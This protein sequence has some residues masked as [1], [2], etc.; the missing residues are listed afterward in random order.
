M[1]F[2]NIIERRSL[3][4]LRILII[5]KIRNKKYKTNSNWSKNSKVDFHYKLFKQR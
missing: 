4:R 3:L 2:V 5:N 1:G